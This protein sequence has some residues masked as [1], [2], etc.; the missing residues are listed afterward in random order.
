MTTAE[1]AAAI[2]DQVAL[3]GRMPRKRMDAIS[4]I[5]VIRGLSHCHYC[6]KQRIPNLETVIAELKTLREFEILARSAQAK[7]FCIEN[8]HRDPN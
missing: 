8:V 7:H 1:L 2:R 5:E 3:Q 4:D 6:G